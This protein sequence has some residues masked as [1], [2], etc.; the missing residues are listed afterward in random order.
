MDLLDRLLGHDA[1]TTRHILLCCREL[2]EP[3]LLQ[4]FE[5]GHGSVLATFDHL[6]GNVVVWTDLMVARPVRPWPAQRT[7]ES[8]IERQAA[9]AD[10]F[11]QLARSVRDANRWDAEWVDVLDKP[12]QRKTFGGAIAHV[13]THSHVHRGEILHMLARLGVQDLIEGDALSWEQRH[14]HEG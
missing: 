10:E 9:A 14:R 3:Q 7:L 8:L 4:P 5:I 11:T 1:W 12:P 2:T 6:I 13:L